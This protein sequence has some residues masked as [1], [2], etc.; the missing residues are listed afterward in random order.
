MAKKIAVIGAGVSGISASKTLLSAGFEVSLFDQG[1]APGGRLGLRTLKI[2]PNEN[3]NIDVGAAYFT[4]QDSLFKEKVNEWVSADLAFAWEEDFQVIENNQRIVKPGPN[5][6][7]VRNGIKNIVFFELE[8]IKNEIN[9][10]KDVK[11]EA[12]E[13]KGN[14]V[15]VNKSEFDAAVLAMPAPQAARIVLEKDLQDEL[16]KVKFNPVLVAWVALKDLEVFGGIFVNK[17][18]DISLLINEGNKQ[19]DG[20]NI[21]T[22]YSTHEFASNQIKD[23][24]KAK[25]L[26]IEKAKKLLGNASDEIESGI[27]RWTLAQPEFS[28]RPKLTNNLAIVGD[29]YAENPRIENAWLDGSR[30]LDQLSAIL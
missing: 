10:F 4:V 11:V 8:K 12:I 5:R 29:A 22:I 7:V 21:L 23:L 28:P 27:M 19:G 2:S 6:Y 1:K 17:D 18:L 15:T 24:E 16:N 14:K 3:R 9:F 13:L 20:A 26:L 30:V 25:K